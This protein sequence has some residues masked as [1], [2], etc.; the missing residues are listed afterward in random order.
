LDAVMLVYP[1]LHYIVNK[2]SNPV[3]GTLGQPSSS[4]LLIRNTQFAASPHANSS[5]FQT[6]TIVANDLPAGS[7]GFWV[8]GGHAD[9]VY[10]V[11][12]KSAGVSR[13][14]KRNSSGTGWTQLNVS[15]LLDGINPTPE[16]LPY[17][18]HGPVF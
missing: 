3:P 1:P 17:T 6:W 18:P 16:G 8:S 10:Y 5:Q 12:A 7:E 2:V 9:P 4:P 13:L 11:I 14:Y 15:G